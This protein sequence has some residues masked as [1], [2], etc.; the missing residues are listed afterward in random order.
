MIVHPT[1]VH[2][3]RR[4][5]ANRTLDLRGVKAIGYDLDY[6]LVHYKV[7]AWEGRAYEHLQRRL[8][9]RGWPVEHL[10]FD[11]GLVMRGLVI[12]TERGNL[13]KVNR[14]GYVKAALHGTERMPWEQTRATYARTVVDLADR[15]WDF[16]NTLFSLSEAC[17]YTQLV[18]LFDAGKLK[19]PTY[20]DLYRAV[21]AALNRTHVEGELKEE[22]ERDPH[23]F[24]ELD[25]ELPLALLDQK[26]AG[27]K[28]MVITNS[29]WGYARAMLDH[30]I[31]PFLPDGTTWRDLFDLTVVAARKPLFFTDRSPMFRLATEDGLVAPMSGSPTEGGVYLGGHAD[32]IEELLGVRGEDILYVGDHIYA[33]VNV[34]K[35]IRRWRTALV[36]RE[37]ERELRAIEG[38]SED[39][40]R[41]NAWMEQKMVHEH[42]ANEARLGLLRLRDGYATGPDDEETLTSRLSAHKGAMG[43]LDAKISPL[44]ADDGAAFS[45]VWGLLLRAG[46]DKSHLTRQIE[47]HADIYTSRVS[48][49]LG[50][51]PFAIFRSPRGSMPHDEPGFQGW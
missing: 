23:A 25:P 33:D 36:L 45:K 44:L 17:M 32:H 22:I 37:L 47:R 40:A 51:T 35:R 28:L 18:P 50:Y 30:A 42:A 20:A 39:H 49:F 1:H 5:F 11:P 41:I 27:K 2:P 19:C 10:A 3:H 31:T 26:R 43:V 34:S 24:V 12:D 15:R 14:F 21:R 4:I 9:E 8:V 29:E 38:E 16:A 6:T 13:L 48:N 46:N 7:R